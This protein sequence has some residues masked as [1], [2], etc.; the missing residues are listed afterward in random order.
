MSLRNESLR[1][2]SRAPAGKTEIRSTKPCLTQKDLTLA[3][4]PGVAEPCLEIAKKSGDVYKYTNKGNLVAVLSNGSAVL[5]LGNIGPLAFKPVGEGKAVLFKKFAGVD[6]FDLEV[7]A[8]DPEAIIAVAKAVA[9]TFGGINLEDIKAPECFEVEERLKSEL[10]IPVFHDDQW[11]TAIISS[12]GLIN[13]FHLTKRSWDDTTTVINGAGAAGIAMARLL[14][15]LGHRKEQILL[16]DSRGVV[17]KGRKEGINPYK[18]SFAVETDKRTLAEALQGADVFLGVSVADAVT[19]DMVKSMAPNPVIFA[20]ANPDPEIP[21]A[22]VKKARPDAIV[23]TGRSDHPNQVNNVLGFPFIF[24]GALDVA[25]RAINNEMMVAA[26]R[27]LADLAREPIPE[28]VLAD[29]GGD[30]LSFGPDYVI[31]KPTDRRVLFHVA[32]A[33]A[34]AAIK[35]GVA[36]RPVDIDEYRASLERLVDPGRRLLR[37]VFARARTL[38][39]PARILFPEGSNKTVLQ[40]AEILRGDGLARPVLVGDPATIQEAASKVRVDTQGMEILNPPH[41][42]ALKKYSLSFHN[43]RKRRGMTPAEAHQRLLD[44]IVFGAMHLREGGVDGLIVG[45]NIH[46]RDALVPLLQILPLSEGIS[47]AIGAY[48]IIPQNRDISPVVLG[49]AT[50]GISPTA[51]L[52]AETGYLLARFAKDFLQLDPIVAFLSHSNFGSGKS[53]S[54]RTIQKG[55]AL[56]KSAYP[57]IPADGEMQADTALSPLILKKAYP[58]SVLNECGQAN[59][60][61]APD[62]DSANIAYKLLSK[63]GEAVLVGP[64]L[65]GMKHPVHVLQR[66]SSVSQ[67]V[68]L[69]TLSAA[70][71]SP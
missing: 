57:E 67:V 14:V 8:T 24:R 68:E 50:I 7:D 4:S 63:L 2:H 34:D 11:G 54:A 1:Y 49:D 59:V 56:F 20:M 47:H 10:S 17:Y 33:V 43:L 22:E 37:P 51:D 29:Y 45:Q 38:A 48:A 25:A 3:Y 58:F 42:A 53:S 69:A 28:E 30:P 41:H 71:L 26:S 60:L 18:A 52:L 35:T 27:A 61:V 15:T 6:A 44:P 21:Y 36:R 31:P 23:G 39:L 40:A 65:L 46:Y 12:A 55:V 66:H 64:L 62:L 9:P 70:R 5:G 16:C 13:A 19:P 32:P